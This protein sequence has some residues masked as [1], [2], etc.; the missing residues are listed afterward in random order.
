M[1][2][3]TVLYIHY[4]LVSLYS[5]DTLSSSTTHKLIN[6]KMKPRFFA[7]FA[8]FCCLTVLILRE[9][10]ARREIIEFKD[11]KNNET[12]REDLFEI[13]MTRKTRSR[14]ALDCFGLGGTLAKVLDFFLKS[15]SNGTSMWTQKIKFYATSRN[16]PERVALAHGKA[17]NLDNVDFDITRRTV[18]I[19][20]GFL[21][22]GDE[23]WI[24]DMNKALLKWVCKSFLISCTKLLLCI[25][26]SIF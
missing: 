19:V 20:H 12:C 13:G 15:P 7:S 25:S 22:S 26:F 10:E 3:H 5:V 8:V 24:K 18:L 11:L 16:M 23:K 14:E 2:V 6:V 17:F 1:Y 9:S 21:A 4:S